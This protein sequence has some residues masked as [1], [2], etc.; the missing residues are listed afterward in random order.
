MLGLQRG[1]ARRRGVRLLGLGSIPVIPVL[2][3]VDIVGGFLFG[4]PAWG[5]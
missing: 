4:R 2:F 5:I 1:A 3:N